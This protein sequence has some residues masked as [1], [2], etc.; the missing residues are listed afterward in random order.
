MTIVY[1]K[2]IGDPSFS[3]LIQYEV[4]MDSTLGHCVSVCEK[5]SKCVC[6]VF[7]NYCIYYALGPNAVKADINSL[8]VS[9]FS[10]GGYAIKQ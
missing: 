1:D 7:M 2:V 9:A 6:T 4:S 8:P 3:V 10:R 5:E